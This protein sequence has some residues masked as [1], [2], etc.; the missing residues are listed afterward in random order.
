[1]NNEKIQNIC[2]LLDFLGK[3]EHIFFMSEDEYKKEFNW[4][5]AKETVSYMSGC[6]CLGAT[7]QSRQP[8]TNTPSLVAILPDIHFRG[9][10][11]ER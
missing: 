11:H 2:K 3:K 5:F 1:M 10:R 6:I 4:L 9:L 7:V 8:C